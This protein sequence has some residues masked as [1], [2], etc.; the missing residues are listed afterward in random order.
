MPASPAYQAQDYKAVRLRQF[1]KT[2]G[3]TEGN[4]RK[5]DLSEGS[6]G[7]GFIWGYKPSDASPIRF[8]VRFRANI[9]VYKISKCNIS[10]QKASHCQLIFYLAVEENF[11]AYWRF[12]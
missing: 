10:I 1:G 8:I 11:S 7:V 3:L 12:Q 4:L 9:I 5:A 2:S 6:D